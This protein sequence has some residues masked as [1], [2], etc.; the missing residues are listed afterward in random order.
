MANV[1]RV[2][3]LKLAL[4][5]ACNNNAHMLIFSRYKVCYVHYFNLAS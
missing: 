2:A 5:L 1:L 4:Q 3:M